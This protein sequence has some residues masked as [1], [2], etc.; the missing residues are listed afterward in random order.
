MALHRPAVGEGCTG[1]G[2]PTPHSRTPRRG[3]RG[4]CGSR[5]VQPSGTGQQHNTPESGE[6]A[7]HHVEARLAVRG[8]L[9]DVDS[10]RVVLRSAVHRAGGVVELAEEIAQRLDQVRGD[11]AAAL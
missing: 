6:P 7:E 1:R 2:E 10:V 9:R 4:A 5:A 8:P 3:V 11:D